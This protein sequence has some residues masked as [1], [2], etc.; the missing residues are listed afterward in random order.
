MID[1]LLS[2]L[3]LKQVDFTNINFFFMRI[4]EK[5]FVFDFF[6]KI[7]SQL[8]AI[9]VDRRLERGLNLLRW[10]NGLSFA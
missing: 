7:F 4:S 5:D 2:F 8:W 1:F 10:L 6:P 3:F 9:L